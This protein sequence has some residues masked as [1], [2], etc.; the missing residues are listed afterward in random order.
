MIVVVTGFIPL[1]SLSIVSAIV[2]WE[3]S[4]WLRKNIV[5][6]YRLKEFQ[7]SMDRWTDGC[8]KT[9]ITLKLLNT[10]Q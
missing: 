7:E 5:Q 1:S 6:E 2:I 8:N 4:Q 3:S 9:E 10:I